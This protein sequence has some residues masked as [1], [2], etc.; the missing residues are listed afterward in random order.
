MQ[1]G[2]LAGLGRE[3]RGEQLRGDVAHAVVRADH[4]EVE[5][6]EVHLIL[7]C[8]APSRFQ[9]AHRFLDEIGEVLRDVLVAHAAQVVEVRVLRQPP[10]KQGPGEVVHGILLGLYGASH[11]LGAQLRVQVLVQLRLEHRRGL[12]DGLQVV[13]RVFVADDAHL[14][15]R[16]AA[17]RCGE[18][19]H[20]Q[21][22]RSAGAPQSRAGALSGLWVQDQHATAA[23]L[24][25]QHTAHRL[26]HDDRAEPPAPESRF[27]SRHVRSAHRLVDIPHSRLETPPQV[28]VL[29]RQLA[30]RRATLS[31]RP[32]GGQEVLGGHQVHEVLVGGEH[33]RAHSLRQKALHLV[34]GRR[35]HVVHALVVVHVGDDL[36]LE[37]DG[38]E[39]RGGVEGEHRFGRH[40]HPSPDVVAV[41]QAAGESDDPRRARGLVRGVPH[42]GHHHLHVRPNPL[43]RQAVQVVDHQQ[44]QL[45]DDLPAPPPQREPIYLLRGADHDVVG[46]EGLEV[47]LAVAFQQPHRAQGGIALGEFPPGVLGSEGV[48][49]HHDGLGGLRL[50]QELA[51]QGKV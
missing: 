6:H 45:I 43:V 48:G 38:E 47:P 36:E 10:V 44:A 25:R 51:E 5:G 2:L 27:H 8:Y 49:T 26:R 9:L 23:H 39:P 1:Q 33:H 30:L 40:A 24:L 14:P 13:P 17:A 18:S 31:V 4:G 41:G 50:M 34:G 21:H 32:Q 35:R 46:A 20:V 28:A 3:E 16:L 42:A 29:G 12:H 22:L 7:H 37:L 19:R 15:Q 11:H